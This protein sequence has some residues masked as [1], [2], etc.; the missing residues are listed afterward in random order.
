MT[1]SPLKEDP[2]RMQITSMGKVRRG[3]ERGGVAEIPALEKGRKRRNK[4]HAIRTFCFLP[5]QTN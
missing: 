3:R 2:Y 4:E 1:D 5:D